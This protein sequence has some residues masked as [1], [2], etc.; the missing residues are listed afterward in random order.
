MNEMFNNEYNQLFCLDKKI[1][2]LKTEKQEYFLRNIDEKDKNDDVE[3][4]LV[5]GSND[6]DYEKLK[7]GKKKILYSIKQNMKYIKNIEFYMMGTISSLRKEGVSEEQ[8]NTEIEKTRHIYEKRILN[9]KSILKMIDENPKLF[10]RIVE[11]ESCN[12]SRINNKDAIRTL[13]DYD[14]ELK[15]YEKERKKLSEHLNANIDDSQNNKKNHVF[16]FKPLF[17]KKKEKRS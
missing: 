9:L 4:P 15:D 6:S 5:S 2:K 12:Y 7:D 17:G 3:I 10:L 1:D 11:C 16:S 14:R 8:I 13:K